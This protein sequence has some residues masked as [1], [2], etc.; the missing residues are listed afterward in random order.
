[1]PTQVFVSTTPTLSKFLANCEV[2]GAKEH[3]DADVVDMD[4]LYRLVSEHQKK[5][6]DG[7]PK[8]HELL[9]GSE[10]VERVD[11]RG[12][13]NLTEVERMRLES[14]ERAYQR[15]V[16]GLVKDSASQAKRRKD[17]TTN[18]GSALGFASNFAS[19]TLVAFIGGFAF[20][21]FF[22]E[23]FVAQDNFE[24][25]VIA[26]AACSF[27]TLLLETVLLVVRESKESKIEEQR[28]KEEKRKMGQGA[29]G[30]DTF[31]KAHAEPPKPADEKKKD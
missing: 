19:Q 15:S 22:V 23:T 8:L 28:K 29:R 5:V 12:V 16:G 11:N 3:R 7:A 18:V 6:G 26:G 24:A 20:G 9:E 2:D 31:S 21:Y 4:E 17:P 14:Q 10:V 30:K 13:D 25:K 27:L 1:M